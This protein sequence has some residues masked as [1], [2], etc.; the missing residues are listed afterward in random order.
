M[1]LGR[2]EGLGRCIIR[3]SHR[4]GKTSHIH[5]TTSPF[6]SPSSKVSPNVLSFSSHSFCPPTWTS[7]RAFKGLS[8]YKADGCM[9][10]Y[11]WLQL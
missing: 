1:D 7:P 3:S 9:C 8:T 11:S 2:G 6:P 4:R 5:L 10:P